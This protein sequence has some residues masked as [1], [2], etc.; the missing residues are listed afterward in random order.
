M[1]NKLDSLFSTQL[2]VSRTFGSLER[3]QIVI[4]TDEKSSPRI[5]RR[6]VAYAP[7]GGIM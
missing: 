7:E 4:M 6:P 5:S 1:K 3:S 2:F